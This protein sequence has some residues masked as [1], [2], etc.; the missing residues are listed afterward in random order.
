MQFELVIS[1]TASSETKNAY[2][3]YEETLV[4]LGERFLKSLEATYKQLSETP[5]YYGYITDAKDLRDVKVKGFPF[6]VIFQII[7][8][9]V[10]VLRVFNTNRNL[11]SLR[12]L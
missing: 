8:N 5:K 7:N 10:F 6:V 4:G 1:P 9:Q 11:E 2:N 3:F 12:N